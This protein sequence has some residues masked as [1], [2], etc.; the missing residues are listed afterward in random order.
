[1][2][3]GV[4]ARP[5]PKSREPSQVSPCRRWPTGSSTSGSWSCS[6]WSLSERDIRRD[7][8]VWG[9][10]DGCP[11]DG[12]VPREKILADLDRPGTPYWRLKKL[13]DAWC[14]LWFWP[15]DKAGLLDGTDPALSARHRPRSPTSAEVPAFEAPVVVREG[16]TCSAGWNRSSSPCRRKTTG[17][18]QIHAIEKSERPV[19]LAD[20]DDWLTSPRH[21]SAR[22]HPGRFAGQRAS[23]RWHELSDVRGFAD[24]PDGHG[25]GAP[26]G[27]RFPWLPAAE[28]IADQQGFFHWELKFAQVFAKGGFDLQVGNPPWVRPRWQEDAVL[29]EHEPWFR[30]AEK[31]PTAEVWRERKFIALAGARGARFSFPS[32]LPTRES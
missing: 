10:D 18:R 17:T 13:M 29:A 19:P 9:A 25:A 23:P 4:E 30:L 14:A 2:A 6:A 5:S 21:C 20:L 24:R 3:Y 8:P 31:P 1:M 27:G 26:A 16:R 22:G 11:P 15:V 28:Q 12:A 7:I 32:L